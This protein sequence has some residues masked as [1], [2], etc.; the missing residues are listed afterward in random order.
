MT[1]QRAKAVYWQTIVVLI[2]TSLLIGAAVALQFVQAS[3][4]QDQEASQPTVIV[5]VNPGHPANRF[6]PSH[7]FGAG[8]D[9]HDKGEADRQLT[10]ENIRAMRSAGLQ[11]LTYR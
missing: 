10:P 1:S 3:D 9:G 4:V 8:V 2:L 6:V 5:L 7:A 11:S